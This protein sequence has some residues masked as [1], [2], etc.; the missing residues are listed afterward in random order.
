M[1]GLNVQDLHVPGDTTQYPTIT[2]AST[3]IHVRLPNCVT[4][5]APVSMSCLI[6]T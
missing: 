5:T 4:A 6:D 2:P 1:T 3:D